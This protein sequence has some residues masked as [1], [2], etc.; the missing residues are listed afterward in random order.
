MEGISPSQMGA[1]VLVRE[2]TG[3]SY[4]SSPEAV[5]KAIQSGQLRSCR[6]G[7]RGEEG[8]T[9]PEETHS[10]LQKPKPLWLSRQRGNLGALQIEE[11]CLEEPQRH[12]VSAH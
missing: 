6:D 9:R 3:A 2:D 11:V 7:T 10:C 12:H 5:T 4:P 8:E 1:G